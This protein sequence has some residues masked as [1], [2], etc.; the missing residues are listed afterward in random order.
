MLHGIKQALLDEWIETYGALNT[1]MFVF[2][3]D[4]P[5]RQAMHDVWERFAILHVHQFRAMV[6]RYRHTAYFKHLFQQLC[7]LKDFYRI[8]TEIQWH[9]DDFDT[10]L[11]TYGFYCHPQHGDLCYRATVTE[12]VTPTGRL[13]LS[14]LLPK[15]IGTANTFDQLQRE[16]GSGIQRLTPWPHPALCP[17]AESMYSG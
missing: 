13:Y 2:H 6:L 11:K 12:R 10:S 7:K 4:S 5:L 3:P 8:W 9:E 1:L 17:D 15:N 16:H 14:T